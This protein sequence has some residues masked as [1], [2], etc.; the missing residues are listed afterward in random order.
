M[1]S[2][3]GIIACY[4]ATTEFNIFAMTAAWSVSYWEKQAAGHFDAHTRDG[5]LTFDAQ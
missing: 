1:V 4:M 3:T 2:G 5:A